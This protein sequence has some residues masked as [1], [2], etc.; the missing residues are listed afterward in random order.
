MRRSIKE[1]HVMDVGGTMRVNIYETN[2]S[3]QQDKT[4]DLP[5][6]SVSVRCL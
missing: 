5:P 3:K 4:R 1:P 6:A 2:L